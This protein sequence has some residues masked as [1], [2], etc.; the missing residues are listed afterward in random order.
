MMKNKELHTKKKKKNLLWGI[1]FIKKKDFKIFRG[2]LH[3]DGRRRWGKVS[4]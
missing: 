3:R 2:W 4:V 1:K